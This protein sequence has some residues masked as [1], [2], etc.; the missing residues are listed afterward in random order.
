MNRHRLGLNDRFRACIPHF[1]SPP[2]SP[3]TLD[4]LPDAPEPQARPRVTAAMVPAME[5]NKP[6]RPPFWQSRVYGEPYGDFNRQPKPHAVVKVDKPA[7]GG[8]AAAG[9]EDMNRHLRAASARGERTPG[10]GS[11]PGGGGSRPKSAAAA[12]N[13][14]Y[15]RPAVRGGV[16]EAAYNHNLAIGGKL[17]DLEVRRGGI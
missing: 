16:A 13:H 1:F 3:L 9:G 14:G 15:G 17:Q 10:G 2:D 8:R 4:P 5:N 12:K 7:A 6:Y 11:G